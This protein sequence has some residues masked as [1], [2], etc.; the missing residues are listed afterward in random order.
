MVDARR[1]N[2]LTVL[3]AAGL[4]GPRLAVTPDLIAAPPQAISL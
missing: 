2:A 1:F 3:P 4:A